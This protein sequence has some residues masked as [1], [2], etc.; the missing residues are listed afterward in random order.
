VRR[1]KQLFAALIE[2]ANVVRASRDAARGKR[3]RREVLSFAFDLEDELRRTRRDL[4]GGR[5]PLG[6]LPA[7]ANP[8]PE[9]ARDPRPGRSATESSIKTV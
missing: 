5:V 3:G 6:R 4:Y 1:A 2:P 7:L 9:A 8:R